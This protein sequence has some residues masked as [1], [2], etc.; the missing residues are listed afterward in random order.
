MSRE[1]VQV[2]VLPPVVPD[3]LPQIFLFEDGIWRD[4]TAPQVTEN[5]TTMRTRIEQHLSTLMA[6]VGRN[7]PVPVPPQGAG[8]KM[9][10][11]TLYQTLLPIDV[12]NELKRAADAAQAAGGPKPLVQIFL[13]STAEWI[14]WE[15]LHDGTDFLGL[16][17][18]VARLPIVKQQTSVRGP[19]TRTV[20]AVHSILAS[21]VLGPPEQA[22]WATTF[23]GF[24]AAPGWQRRSPDGQNG[25]GPTLNE[26]EQ[27]RAAGIVHVTCHG[28]LREGQGPFFW[29]LDHLNAQ[30]Y[31]YRITADFAERMEFED[32]PLVFG[33]ACASNATDLGALH[34]F[35]SSFM[36]GGALNFIGTVAPITKTTA[37]A[38]AR[39]FYEELFSSPITPVA[40]ADALRQTK[41][42]F[43]AAPA[44]STDPSYLFYCL[45]GPPDTTFKPV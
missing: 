29:T 20:S 25:P 6:N 37:V 5:L 28:G 39:Q 21:S 41:E 24:S 18:S 45:Y 3:G 12:R 15:L 34:G 44:P 23:D 16:R 9:P 32:R 27:A 36:I 17:F 13:S 30:Y 43:A 11:R 1:V 35:G 14:P 33:N 7:P 26:I 19:R 4:V 31:D 10:F 2:M 8:F 42:R 38:F 22:A 40:I